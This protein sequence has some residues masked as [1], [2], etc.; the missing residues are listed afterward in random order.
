MKSWEYVCFIEDERSKVHG[1]IGC[2]KSW[3]KN[4]WRVISFNWGP[5]VSA[6]MEREITEPPESPTTVA[7]ERLPRGD[8]YGDV[9]RGSPENQA[10]MKKALREDDLPPPS[11]WPM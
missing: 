10:F 1:V 7:E 4:G 6:L 8:Q 9:I 2:I 3:A 11:D 5:P